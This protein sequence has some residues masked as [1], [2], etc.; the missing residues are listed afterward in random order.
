VGNVV[1]IA[2]QQAAP[3]EFIEEQRRSAARDVRAIV[4][5][6]LA[7]AATFAGFFFSLLPWGRTL[8]WDGNRR[9]CNLY[10]NLATQASM[11][12]A[13]AIMRELAGNP[14][15]LPGSFPDQ[16]APVAWM[17][18]GE[19]NLIQMRWGFPPSKVA[20][21]SVDFAPNPCNGLRQPDQFRY[22]RVS[23]WSLSTILNPFCKAASKH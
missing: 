8:H 6:V 1:R 13:F 15:P 20:R 2:R 11:A 21:M 3:H 4:F 5:V 22:H 7:I 19:R 23:I 18:D 14:P 16:I 12:K 10:S 17:R 9:V